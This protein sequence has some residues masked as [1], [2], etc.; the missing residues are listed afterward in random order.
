MRH[1]FDQKIG[2]G[3]PKDWVALGSHGGDVEDAVGVHPAA[4]V[5]MGG[6]PLPRECAI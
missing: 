5:A 4:F 1:R 3:F 2:R 6:S